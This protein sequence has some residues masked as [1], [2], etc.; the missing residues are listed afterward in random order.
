[1]I[2]SNKKNRK[3]ENP[4]KIYIDNLSIKQDAEMKFLGIII[5]ENL[6]WDNHIKTVCNIVSKGIGII[7]YYIYLLRAIVIRHV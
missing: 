4:V 5:T 3:V 2:F 6:N 7:Y 1:M